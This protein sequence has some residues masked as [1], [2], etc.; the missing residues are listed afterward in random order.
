MTN[1]DDKHYLETEIIP[2]TGN[3]QFKHWNKNLGKT[4]EYYKGKHFY[5]IG[6]MTHKIGAIIGTFIRIDRNCSNP[7]LFEEAL[8]EKVRE[9]L[10]L[11][12]PKKLISN[13]LYKMSIK[14]WCEGQAFNADK[15]LLPNISMST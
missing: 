12:Y 10:G 6:P 15:W 7:K 9:L 1:D 8:Q 11:K 2:T 4:Q 14:G 3:V 13:I 5:S